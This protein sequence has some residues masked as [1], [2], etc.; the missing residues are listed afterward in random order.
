MAS[1][2]VKIQESDDEERLAGFA[3]L[4][5]AVAVFTFAGGQAFEWGKTA[6]QL[7]L[8]VA[9]PALFSGIIALVRD[10]QILGNSASERLA[11]QY[12]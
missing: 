4:V 9:I 10:A 5:L 8:V 3:F 6:A 12:P 11:P 7:S 2:S 1:I